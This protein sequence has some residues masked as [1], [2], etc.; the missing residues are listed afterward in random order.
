MSESAP[1]SAPIAPTPPEKVFGAGLGYLLGG[2]LALVLLYALYAFGVRP[3]R[4]HGSR[5]CKIRCSAASPRS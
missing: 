5:E 1:E 2:I 3:V 4:L